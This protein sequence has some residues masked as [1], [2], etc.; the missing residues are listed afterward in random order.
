MCPSQS[1]FL[2][3]PSSYCWVWGSK[4]PQFPHTLYVYKKSGYLALS[5]QLIMMTKCHDIMMLFK[6]LVSHSAVQW[7][8]VISQ[9][10]PYSWK[11]NKK[12]FMP[13]SKL[14]FNSSH[15]NIFS[16]TG[17]LTRPQ[18]LSDPF[19][20]ES[21]SSVSAACSSPAEV[22]VSGSCGESANQ[23]LRVHFITAL[24]CLCMTAPCS[25]LSPRWSD[26]GAAACCLIGGI[27]VAAIPYGLC[28]RSPLC[29]SM[30]SWRDDKY[31]EVTLRR[32]SCLILAR[33]LREWYL[34]QHIWEECWHT[35]TVLHQTRQ[36]CKRHGG[37]E[38]DRREG[39][40]G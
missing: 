6:L 10:Q 38:T 15:V 30:P 7:Q 2:L 13:L 25:P 12:R 29:S 16:P 14:L 39:L 8:Q 21:H 24:L 17:M 37:R 9:L 19:W 31:L 32:R 28:P 40:K 27:S 3:K 20:K 1:I 11:K 22:C 18:D 23:K 35:G 5:V 36:K 4:F 33:G 34:M 26:T